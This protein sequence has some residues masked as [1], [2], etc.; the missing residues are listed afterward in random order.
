MPRTKTVAFIDAAKGLLP[1]REI[2]VPELKTVLTARGLSARQMQELNGKATGADGEVDAQ[3][4][5]ELVIA[6]SVVDAKGAP[7]VAP[8]RESEIFDI[9]A[10][11][12]QRMQAAVTEV[13]GIE[14]VADAEKN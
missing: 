13:C 5:T 14:T 9:P 6:A 4:L 3:L 12:L 11:I 1:T 10:A 7:I 2:P 8:G